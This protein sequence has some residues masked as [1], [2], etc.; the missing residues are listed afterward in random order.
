MFSTSANTDPEPYADAK[1]GY[2]GKWWLGG[3]DAVQ[4]GVYPQGSIYAFEDIKIN[5]GWTNRGLICLNVHQWSSW[6]S[7]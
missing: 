5:G 6:P 4:V 3:K 2:V 1:I 7:N